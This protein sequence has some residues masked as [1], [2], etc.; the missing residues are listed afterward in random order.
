MSVMSRRKL[1]NTKEFKI[2]VHKTA[3]HFYAQLV[4]VE[5]KIS[6]SHSTL[7]LRRDLKKQGKPVNINFLNATFVREISKKFAEKISE[8]SVCD[9]VCYERGSKRYSG[10]VKIFAEGLRENGVFI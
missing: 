5:G 9:N 10:L 6:C 2:C 3:Q 8:L 1:R 4:N 7:S